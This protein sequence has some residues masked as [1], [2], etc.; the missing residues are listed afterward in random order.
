[1][2]NMNNMNISLFVLVVQYFL[3]EK[4][5]SS[6]ITLDLRSMASFYSCIS[7]AGLYLYDGSL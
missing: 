7:V 2:E 1:M 3:R 4:E 5:E 6:V